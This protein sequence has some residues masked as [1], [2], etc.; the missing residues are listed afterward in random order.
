M[1]NK[2]VSKMILISSNLI[3]KKISNYQW[4]FIDK[5]DVNEYMF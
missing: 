4:N 1:L 5:K 2:V 3:I